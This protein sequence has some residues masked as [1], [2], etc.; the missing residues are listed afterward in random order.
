[1]LNAERKTQDT[2]QEDADCILRCAL[3]VKQYL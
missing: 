1:M 2:K 3:S